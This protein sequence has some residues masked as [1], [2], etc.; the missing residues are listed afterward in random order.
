MQVSV[1]LSLWRR[2]II[3]GHLWIL[4]VI[5]M[6]LIKQILFFFSSMLSYMMILLILQYRA[7]TS[8]NFS[9][10]IFC[11]T[12]CCLMSLKSV[13]AEMIINSFS[14]WTF[15]DEESSIKLKILKFILL[16]HIY[17]WFLVFPVQRAEQ[18]NLHPTVLWIS[19]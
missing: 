10:K 6:F 19:Y 4:F 15:T 8:K 17:Y 18:K 12:V 9:T 14:V 5:I 3:K 13:A 2:I 1:F 7:H 16:M 11:Q